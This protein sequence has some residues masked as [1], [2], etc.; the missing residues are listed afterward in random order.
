MAPLEGREVTECV[1]RFVELS[2]MAEEAARLEE[3]HKRSRWLPL[4]DYSSLELVTE[5]ENIGY[6]RNVA[7][8][9]ARCNEDVQNILAANLQRFILPQTR[10]GFRM[11]ANLE[12]GIA[13]ISHANLTEVAQIVFTAMNHEDF[14]REACIAGVSL[15]C[16][17]GIELWDAFL[18]AAGPFLTGWAGHPLESFQGV[19][20]SQPAAILK[21]AELWGWPEIFGLIMSAT[22]TSKV[23]AAAAAL[24]EALPDILVYLRQL[25]QHQERVGLRLQLEQLTEIAGLSGE[26]LFYDDAATGVK[27]GFARILLVI[28]KRWPEACVNVTGNAVMVGRL[29]ERVESDP[30]SYLEFADEVF[31]VVARRS[32]AGDRSFNRHPAFEALRQA[33][34]KRSHEEGAEEEEVDEMPIPSQSEDAS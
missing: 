6:T 2:K 3:R 32:T 8:V 15:I 24:A 17:C 12:L 25:L 11:V 7:C 18:G 27:R 4:P 23:G 19:N 20:F 10:D 1:R 34:V 13:R 21:L 14:G 28:S 22:D 33:R 9:A 26:A 16:R 30:E 5:L 31:S 29:L